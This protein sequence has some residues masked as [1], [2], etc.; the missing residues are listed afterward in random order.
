MITVADSNNP[1]VSEAFSTLGEVRL[2]PCGEIT[3]EVLKDADILAC[4]STVKVNADLLDGTAVKYVAT[5][6]IGTDHLDTAYLDARGIRHC[7]APGCN[8]DSV[9]DYITAALLLAGQRLGIALE[10]K[11]LGVIGCGNVGSRVVKR[12]QAL[13]MTVIE[14]DP[15]LARKT[16]DPRYRPL[17]ELMDADFITLHTP[18]TKEGEDKTFHLVN[19][20]FFAKLRPGAVFINAARGAVVDTA[21]L[22]SAL[23]GQRIA[24]A[25]LDV[26][27]GE[28]APNPTLLAQALLGTPHIAG[29]SF[30]GKVNGTTGIYQQ[31]CEWIGA[32]PNFDPTPLLPP[33]EVAALTL[34]CANRSDED[35]IRR[36]VFAV[37]PILE[38]D[39][40]YRE[41]QKSTDPKIRATGFSAL[42]KNYP[43]RREFRWTT[44]SLQNASPALIAK[45][46]GLTFQIL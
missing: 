14:N 38:D 25:L 46:R 1:F 35:V 42:R 17:S 43:G 28:P 27:E 41:S 4:R 24:A 15:L 19:A 23:S 31:V 20:D 40:R 44:L 39:A 45:L 18:L 7:N 30:D 9:A 29:H 3:R 21:A 22:M 32:T 5:A 8:A 36:A 2:F 34:D 6:T 10:G 13:G 16:S 11:T 33:T 26:W 37:Y 12:A